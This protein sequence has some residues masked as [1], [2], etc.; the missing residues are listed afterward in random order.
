MDS[1]AERALEQ[2]ARDIRG[3]D[4]QPLA[5]RDVTFVASGR[6]FTVYRGRL[7]DGSA[8]GLRIVPEH[9]LADGADD[10]VPAAGIIRQEALLSTHCRSHGIPAPEILGR[11]LHADDAAPGLDLIVYRWLDGDETWPPDSAVGAMLNRIHAL[12]PPAF[13]PVR[14]SGPFEVVIAHRIL[15]SLA[16]VQRRTGQ[17]FPVPGLETLRIHLA[18]PDRKT[19]LLHMGL[20]PGNLMSSGGEIAGVMGWCDALIGPPTFELLSL[21]ERGLLG[22]SLLGGYSGY[23]MFHPPD[24][25]ETVFRLAA[26]A[27]LAEE[28]MDSGRDRQDAERSLNR[29][30]YLS[31]RFVA[32]AGPQ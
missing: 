7:A 25:V 29:V 9:W 30:R 24:P 19:A 5:I 3:S 28:A 27:R 11:S 6:V 15:T 21:D 22:D 1:L 14:Q 8:V 4:A 17:A 20:K 32:L 10:A 26:A 23:E 13:E 16:A 31:E 2:I 12:N 18:W